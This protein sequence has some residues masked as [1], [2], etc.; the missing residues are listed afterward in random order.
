M[1]APM[2][3]FAPLIVLALL[4]TLAHAAAPE[5]GIY[6]VQSYVVS[7]T[8]N[9]GA[10]AGDYLT[11]YFYYPGPD[12]PGAVERHSVNGP[13]NFFVQRLEFPVTPPLN[14]T[15]WSGTYTGRRFPGEGSITA[16]FVTTFTF[17]DEQS[18]LA[19]TTY[20]YPIGNGTCLTVFQNS[21]LRT[22]KWQPH[23]GK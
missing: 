1:E 18:F 16:S 6:S 4:V 22:G 23:S 19:T 14:V 10:Q 20:I 12:K 17:A 11:S 13:Y 7:A 21:Y 3:R 5:P 8:E 15:S 2:P 9:C